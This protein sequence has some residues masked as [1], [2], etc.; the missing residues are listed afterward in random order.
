VSA[1]AV[2]ALH[3]ILVAPGQLTTALATALMVWGIASLVSTLEE[4]RATWLLL[5]MIALADRLAIEQPAQLTEYFTAAIPAD[6]IAA[7]P[8]LSSSGAD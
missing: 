8:R 3:S 1:I 6:R 2:F 7:L 5:A 4:S